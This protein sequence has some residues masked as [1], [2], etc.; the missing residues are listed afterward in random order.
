MDTDSHCWNM[1]L[2]RI[3]LLD[4][5]DHPLAHFCDLIEVLWVEMRHAASDHVVVANRLNLLKSQFIT[6]IVELHE[7]LIQEFDEPL[8]TE[9]LEELSKAD[10]IAKKN[11]ARLVSVGNNLFISQLS[12]SNGLR[13][14]IKEKLFIPIESGLDL[15]RTRLSPRCHLG[16]ALQ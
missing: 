14:D 2:D 1:A 6:K 10:N 4:I 13:Q 3:H 11:T 12:V 16:R 7:H 5:T 15:T 8:C 9:I